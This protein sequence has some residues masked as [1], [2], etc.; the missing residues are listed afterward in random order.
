M[1]FDKISSIYF[2][3]KIY[4]YFNTGNGQPSEPH[5]A[6]CIGALSFRIVDCADVW[7]EPRLLLAARNNVL[8][9][10]PDAVGLRTYELVVDTDDNVTAMAVDVPA[11]TLYYAT[12]SPGGVVHGLSVASG[13]I[14]AVSILNPGTPCVF[15]CRISGRVART[16]FVDAAVP[17][18]SSTGRTTFEG[19]MW[20]SIVK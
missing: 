13:S 16:Q 5:S 2:I 15:C 3:G 6:N 17:H 11:K 19:E 12:A 4:E 14:F 20:R 7:E 9:L 8:K 18:T 1:L 10:V